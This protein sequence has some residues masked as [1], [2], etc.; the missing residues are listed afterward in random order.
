MPGTWRLLAPALLAW[1]ACAAAIPFPGVGRV[2][3]CTAA[4][5]G[6]LVLLCACSPPLRAWLP[7]AA[8]ILIACAA[9]CLLGAQIERSEGARAALRASALPAEGAAADE[10]EVELESYPGVGVSGTR[11]AR[12][13]IMSPGPEAGTDV[14]LWCG[15]TAPACGEATWVLG[16]RLGVRGEFVP[17]DPASSAAAGIRV[18]SVALCAPGPPLSELAGELRTRLGAAAADHAG[19]ALVPGFAVG[20]TSLVA[21]PLSSAMRASGL[22][23]LVA[24]SGANCALITGAIGWG[25]GWLRVGRRWRAVLQCAALGAFVLLV[26]PDASVQRAAI[27]GAVVLVSGFGGRRPAAFPALGLAILVLLCADPWQALQP[28]FALS[29]AATGAILGGAAPLADGLRVR[30]R[31]PRALALPIAVAFVAQL[32]CGPI[33]LLL[34]PGLPAV[35]VLANVLTAP[36]APWGTGLG[37]L[38]LI[39]LP[40]LPAL[41]S[42]ALTAAALPARWV[43]T[44]AVVCSQLPLARWQWPGG[45]GGALLLLAAEL[46]VLFGLVVLVRHGWPGQGALPWGRRPAR[47]P[48]GPRRPCR[49][50]GAGRGRAV[51]APTALARPVLRWAFASLGLGVGVL[52]GPTL[53]IPAASRLGPP[54][55][56][57][58]VACDVG[59]GDA[60]LVRDP[61]HPEET[62]LVDTGEHIEPLNA[63]LDRFGIDRL[64]LLV[65]THDHRDH[66]GALSAVLGRADAALIAPENLADGPARPLVRQLAGAGVPTRVA[67]TGDR[68]G[69]AL[70]WEV[71]APSPDR[72]PTDPND[73]SVVLRVRA[74]ALTVLL[75]GDTG[76]HAQRAFLGGGVCA[77]AGSAADV[78]ADVLKVA[79]H[80]SRDQHP[81][82]ARSVGAEV[83]LISSGVDNTYGHPARET[84]DALADAG[85]IVH[86]TDREGTIAVSGRPGALRV[87]AQQ[88]ARVDGS[89]VGGPG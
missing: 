18:R 88:P 29:V 72:R 68:G 51:P 71:L 33:L 58:V 40:V 86:R 10:F 1:L 65:I 20:D 70:R 77:A 49:A 7:W 19:A 24:V 63:C 66:F 27:M 80:G 17:L 38:A 59:Q 60:V 62:M 14:V 61:A 83:A 16:A 5:L 12:G 4:A 53:V 87:W 37:V 42:G 34:E 8:P 15:E 84:L 3:A 47:G 57:S 82:F 11:W 78:T 48:H 73:S 89:D 6:L 35:S 31:C 25:L 81:C 26:G 55:D 39:L 67:A 13:A 23:H 74:G 43:E 85:S 45:P 28:G 32:A 46:L 22:T 2:M 75:T 21:E 76:E 41:G 54:S 50:R 64:A 79:H 9:I 69:T 56:W 44:T 52:L 36:A 30:L